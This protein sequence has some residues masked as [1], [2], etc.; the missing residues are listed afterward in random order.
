M[1]LHKCS[2]QLL[3][4]KKKKA[5]CSLQAV[6]EAINWQVFVKFTL[7]KTIPLFW[8]PAHTITFMLP[9]NY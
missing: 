5:S 3:E 2:D 7:F 1:A 9:S 6:L 8:K 4:Q